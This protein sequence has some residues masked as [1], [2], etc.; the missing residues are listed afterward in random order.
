MRGK[1]N[2]RTVID[3][4]TYAIIAVTQIGKY[5]PGKVWYGLGRIYLS[6]KLGLPT[7]IVTVSL[8]IEAVILFLSGLLIVAISFLFSIHTF[9]FIFLIPIAIIA[10]IQ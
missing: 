8:F 10:I 7:E 5:I 6:R 1:V 3:G 2:E 9:N 4:K